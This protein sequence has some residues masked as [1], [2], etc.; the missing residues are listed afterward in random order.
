MKQIGLAAKRRWHPVG[1]VYRINPGLGT[2]PGSAHLMRYA[3]EGWPDQVLLLRGRLAALEAKTKRGR[4]EESQLRMA[5]QWWLAGVP[6]FFPTSPE[7]MFELVERHFPAEVW[8]DPTPEERARFREAFA[9]AEDPRPW[10][11]A[12]GY[13]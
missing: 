2:P 7:H 5:R 3:P 4:P 11:E 1:M 12:N 9:D 13:M 6:Y 8:A 10:L